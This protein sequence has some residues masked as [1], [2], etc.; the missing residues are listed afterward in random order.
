MIKEAMNIASLT[1]N[2]IVMINGYTSTQL[3]I[4]TNVILLWI[5]WGNKTTES[6]YNN[7]E[8]R[9]ILKMFWKQIKRYRKMEFELKL[10]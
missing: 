8:V 6:L 10:E 7:E 9:K 2:T 5:F 3:M 1:D 4:K